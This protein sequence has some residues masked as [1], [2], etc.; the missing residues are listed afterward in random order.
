MDNAGIERGGDAVNSL[1]GESRKRGYELGYAHCLWQ[2]QS[3]KGRAKLKVNG[4]VSETFRYL[5]FRQWAVS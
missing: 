2:K 4:G 3:L 1:C 5:C